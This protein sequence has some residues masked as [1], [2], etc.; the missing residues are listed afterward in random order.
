MAFAR[1]I[2]AQHCR[3]ALFNTSGSRFTRTLNMRF[4]ELL[5]RYHA[6]WRKKFTL[7]NMVY[8]HALSISLDT[9]GD[10]Q[11]ILVDLFL[12]NSV[13]MSSRQVRKP[14]LC[15][16]RFVLSNVFCIR[17]SLSMPATSSS[18]GSS[19]IRSLPK[20]PKIFWHCCSKHRTS[21]NTYRART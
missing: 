20:T 4:W 9:C 21:C 11:Y 2:S 18:T 15:D 7:S 16:L 10:D 12:V 8:S 1:G 5:A 17:S 6:P 3:L 19:L 14:I 13:K